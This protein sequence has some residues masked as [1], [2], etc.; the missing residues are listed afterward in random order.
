MAPQVFM[1]IKLL[2]N[3]D[4]SKKMILQMAFQQVKIIGY[5][6]VLGALLGLATVGVSSFIKIPQIQK[7]INP[8]LLEQRVSV[9]NGLCLGGTSLETFSQLIHVVFNSRNGN[10]FVNYGESLLLG[11][12]N[13]VI[14]LLIKYYRLRETNQ[15]SY[16]GQANC[17]EAVCEVAKNLAK[18]AGIMIGSMLFFSKLAPT[19]LVSLLQ[20][21]GI[22]VAIIAK[23]PQI[24]KNR[25]LKSTL[26][27][28]DITLRANLIGSLIRV[29]TSCREFNEKVT[30]KRK[31]S[32]DLV[33]LAGYSAGLIVNSV[34][35]GQSFYY[36]KTEN[37]E[38][39]D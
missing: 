35:V 8:K 29:F 12:Q 30:K 18:P 39:E 22:P 7:I 5:A 25:E 17:K 16:S 37:E 11:I 36:K 10:S 31:S 4:V 1:L 20:I 26:H 3:P 14:I 28:S 13:A 9:A 33:L 19:G 6:K 2:F 34:L 38:K 24:K 21:L 23:L 32:N 27:L 15:I